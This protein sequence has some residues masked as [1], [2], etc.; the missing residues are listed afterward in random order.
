MSRYHHS[1]FGYKPNFGCFFLNLNWSDNHSNHPVFKFCVTVWFSRFGTRLWCWSISKI[2]VSTRITKSRFW[3]WWNEILSIRW[4]P[5]ILFMHTR[6]S[7]FV[8]MRC[9]CCFWWIIESM[10][11]GWKCYRVRTF[12]CHRG[13]RKTTNLFENDKNQIIIMLSMEWNLLHNK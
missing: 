7:S 8:C 6:P 12:G 10:R 5:K 1:I 11:S 9:R 3:N 2:H 4:L 13:T